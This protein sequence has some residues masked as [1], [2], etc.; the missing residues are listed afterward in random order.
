MNIPGRRAFFKF[1]AASLALLGASR[2][3]AAPARPKRKY[4]TKPASEAN[5]YSMAVVT[6]GGRTIWLA[7][8]G[9]PFD[10]SGKPIT[11]FAAQCRGTF[12]NLSHTLEQA[13]G[14][15]SDMVWMIA[16]IS[17]PQYERQFLDLRK[18]I[19]ADNFP[20]S[21]LRIVPVLLPKGMLVSVQGVA[22][23]A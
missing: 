9:A 17:D 16:S 12:A 8:D 5:S 6:Q 11:D 10:A 19:F 2:A 13:G 15:L 3:S 21:A 7:G 23:V 22:V 20:A 14:K 1:G 4:I 18:E